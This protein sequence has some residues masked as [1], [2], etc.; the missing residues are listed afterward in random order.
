MENA[1]MRRATVSAT[2]LLLVAMSA[3]G[4]PSANALPADT[5][6]IEV[7]LRR[8]T[9]VVGQES[10]ARRGRCGFDS[11]PGMISNSMPCGSAQRQCDETPRRP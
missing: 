4:M 7:G 3:I 10:D 1:S 6:P 9:L 11:E 2:T 8:K 5:S